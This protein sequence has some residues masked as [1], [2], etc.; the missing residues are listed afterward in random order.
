MEN[1]DYFKLKKKNVIGET[2]PLTS[3]SSE[4]ETPKVTIRKK[5][6][7]WDDM[8]TS[9]RYS[10]KGVKFSKEEDVISVDEESKDSTK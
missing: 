7:F 4:T 2:L 10:K 5:N 8:S 1:R 9:C 6:S 3:S